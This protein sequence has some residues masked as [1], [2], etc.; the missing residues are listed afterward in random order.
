[1]CAKEELSLKSNISLYL[2]VNGFNGY[3]KFLITLNCNY[4]ICMVL[5][6]SR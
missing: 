5:D 2:S 6:I 1:M 4:L 3:V